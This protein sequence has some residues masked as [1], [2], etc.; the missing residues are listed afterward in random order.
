MLF[1]SSIAES[2]AAT[3]AV[4]SHDESS[5]NQVTAFAIGPDDRYY[6]CGKEDGSVVI[7]ESTDGKKNRKVCNHAAT[8]SVML[9]A[10]SQSGRY[11]VS[12]DDSG[13]VIS[14]RLELKEGGKW[15]V[16]PGMDVRISEAVKQFVFSNDEKLLLIST[17]SKDLVWDLK[18]KKEICS[19]RHRQRE[20]GRWITDH[21]N[22]EMILWIECGKVCSYTWATLETETDSSPASDVVGLANGT[23]GHI[24]GIVLSSDKRSL[25]YETLPTNSEGGPQVSILSTSSLSHSWEVDL[26]G[27]VKRLIGA[28]QNSIVFLDHDYW[29]CTWELEARSSDVKRHFFLPKDWLNTS[30]L[31][32]ATLNEEGTFFCP[33]FGHVIIVRNGMKI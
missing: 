12:S 32:M 17:P 29:V 23:G 16:F 28:F 26:S 19:Q 11:L 15:A 14:K 24:R 9:V 1:R 27:Q 13:R 5:R 20:D 25:I 2:Y 8:S 31:Q 18:G 33:K 3:E 30:T 10:W 4:I 22:P 21:M 6:C 7:H